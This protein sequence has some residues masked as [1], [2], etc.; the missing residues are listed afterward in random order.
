MA[1]SIPKKSLNLLLNC[2]VNA[3]SGN[4]IKACKSLF[5]ISFIRSK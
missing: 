4:I 5:I 3:I 2:S 1:G